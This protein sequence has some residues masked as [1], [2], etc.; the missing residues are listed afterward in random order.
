[1][2][3]PFKVLR[4]M[5]SLEAI[6]DRS[7]SRTPTRSSSTRS[8]PRDGDQRAAPRLGAHDRPRHDQAPLLVDQLRRRRSLRELREKFWAD[9]DDYLIKLSASSRRESYD[10]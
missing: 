9:P 10:R 4:G 5:A 2:K 8:A 1:V 7:T 3:V 6:R